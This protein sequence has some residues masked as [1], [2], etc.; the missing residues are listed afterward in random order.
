M[1]L[2]DYLESTYVTTNLELQKNYSPYLQAKTHAVQGLVDFQRRLYR[3]ASY[4]VLLIGYLLILVGVKATPQTAM[5]IAK[6]MQKEAA[7][8]LVDTP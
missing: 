8:K 5:E 3:Y 6:A 1:K 2:H 4:P 7:V